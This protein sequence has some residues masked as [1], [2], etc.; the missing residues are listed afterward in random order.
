MVAAI[1]K[2]ALETKRLAEEWSRKKAEESDLNTSLL[3][4]EKKDINNKKNG[5]GVM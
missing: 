4:K 1:V 3:G 2:F 5:L